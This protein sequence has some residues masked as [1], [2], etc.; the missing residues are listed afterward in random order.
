MLAREKI[1]EHM[2]KHNVSA[3]KACQALGMSSSSYYYKSPKERLKVRRMSGTSKALTKYQ[4]RMSTI[5]VP[6]DPMPQR[7]MVM[8]GSPDQIRSLIGGVLR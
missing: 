8:I 1:A 7:M 6:D 4:P 5:T 3:S 2:K